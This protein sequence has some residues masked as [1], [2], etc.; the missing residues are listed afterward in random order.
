MK[1][2]VAAAL[3]GVTVML[4]GVWTASEARERGGFAVLDMGAGDVSVQC[5]ARRGLGQPK[6]TATFVYYV[7]MTSQTGGAVRLQFLDNSFIDF[8]IAAGGTLSFSQTGGAVPAVN[9][10]VTITG[11]EFTTDLKGTISAQ[12]D[13]GSQPHPTLTPDYCVTNVAP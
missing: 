7:T 5:G 4:S 8:P 9:G 2:A 11:D 6:A 13:V 3:V 10:V 12:F 1:R